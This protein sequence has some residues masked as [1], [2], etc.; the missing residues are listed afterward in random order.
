M[1]TQLEKA[2]PK[3][4]TSLNDMFGTSVDEVPL[5]VSHVAQVTPQAIK[6]NIEQSVN[7]QKSNFRVSKEE[8][9]ETDETV[10]QIVNDVMSADL[11]SEKMK[12]LISG[13][14]KL[15]NNVVR[16][17][18][19]ANSRLLDISTRDAKSNGSDA[20]K[21]ILTELS[22]L[23]GMALKL[24]PEE[25][26]S[27]KNNKFLKIFNIPFGLGKKADDYMQNFRSSKSQ[28]DEITT[29]LRKGRE[30]LEKSNI[31][32]EEERK[33]QYTRLKE[34]ELYA[35]LANKLYAKL[36]EKYKDLL[37]TEPVKAKAMA[38]ELLHPLGQ[39]R[40]DLAERMAV[41]MQIY[42][43]F[44]T[45]QQN[46]R[47]LIR[48]INRAIDTTMVALS[49]AVI[50]AHALDQQAQI[51]EVLSELSDTTSTI[52]KT[53]ASRVKIQGQA[54]AKAATNATL[55]VESIKFAMEEIV[56]SVEEIQNF[57]QESLGA[58]EQ[59]VDSLNEVSKRGMSVID[60]VA[61]ER[62]SGIMEEVQQEL[63]DENND[64]NSGKIRARF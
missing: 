31:E 62:V 39:K 17:D 26:H 29:N 56:K 47:E 24:N 28:L 23:R 46:N 50:Q 55:D 57:R 9:K 51:I 30:E 59:V 35:Y 12:E 64:K 58:M 13:I 20:T 10:D 22:N 34:H 38:D 8:F 53:N 3:K 4:V 36:D 21:V 42:L 54:I 41:A 33:N 25:M 16:K 49:S 18:N 6:E 32:Y 2:K 1:A 27:Y 7:L 60:R 19:M 52:I 61:S 43:S 15:G 63:E 5:E 44:Q 14:E 37:E 45:I 40:I 48:G 11:H